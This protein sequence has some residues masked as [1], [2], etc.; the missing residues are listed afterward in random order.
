M[1]LK[2]CKTI[3]KK[4]NVISLLKVALVVGVILKLINQRDM[5]FSMQIE[6]IIIQ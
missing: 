4:D 5:L 6:K 1:F 2:I 3:F